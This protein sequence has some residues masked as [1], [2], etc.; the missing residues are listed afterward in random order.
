MSRSRRSAFTLIE[1]LVVIAIIAV[2]IALLLPAVQAAREAARRSQCTNNL[3]QLGLGVH[4]YHTTHDTFPPGAVNGPRTGPGDIYTDWSQWSAQAMLLP[5]VEQ[6]PLYSAANFSWSY[7]PFGDPCG[8][9]NS[10]VAN[11]VIKSFLCPSDPYAGQS[12]N[13]PGANNAPYGS[14]NSYYGSFGT[15]SDNMNTNNPGAKQLSP[16][17]STGLFTYY[18]CYPLS[19]VTDGTSNTIAFGEALAEN[20]GMPTY[21]AN[22]TRGVSDPGAYAFDIRILPVAIVDQ[23]LRNCTDD[24]KS[25]KNPVYQKGLTWAFGDQGVHDVQ[26]HSDSQRQAVSL[27]IVPVRLRWLRDQRRQFR[28]CPEQPPG[29]RQRGDGRWVR[30]VRQGYDQSNDLVGSRHPGQ[31]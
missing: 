29:G 11:T 5:F 6:S 17:G 23:A 3:K 12:G 22:S 30:P 24:F 21:R 4:N 31:W 16:T 1:L 2:L 7:N 18:Q 13:T 20:Q 25:A 27:W 10:T 14:N 28:R 26:Y 8:A 19:R 9:V 15:T